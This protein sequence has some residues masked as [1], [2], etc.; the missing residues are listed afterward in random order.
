MDLAIIGGNVL[1]MDSQ[2]SRA[3]AVATEPDDFDIGLL[4]ISKGQRNSTR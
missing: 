2:N 4:H 1:T 3:E